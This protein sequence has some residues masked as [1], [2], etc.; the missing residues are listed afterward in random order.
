[1]EIL[2][3]LIH[4]SCIPPLESLIHVEVIC[5]VLRPEVRNSEISNRFYFIF[6]LPTRFECRRVL[7][8]HR[9]EAHRVVDRMIADENQSNWDAS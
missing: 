8:S 5:Y 6:S 7:P 9:D 4:M 3:H 1:M 2:S